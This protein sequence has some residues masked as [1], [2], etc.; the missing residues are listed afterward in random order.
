M[1]LRC[2]DLYPSRPGIKLL[3]RRIAKECSD[4]GEGP[5]RPSQRVNQSGVVRLTRRA[6]PIAGYRIDSRRH[7]ESNGC[8]RYRGESAEGRH[9]VLGHPVEAFEVLGE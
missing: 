2:H 1:T 5:A 6:V 7:Q 3:A 8:N 4:V 9:D